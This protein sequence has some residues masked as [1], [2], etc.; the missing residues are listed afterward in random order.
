MWGTEGDGDKRGTDWGQRKVG[1]NEHKPSTVDASSNL[2]DA[3]CASMLMCLCIG[4]PS[5][6]TSTC[7]FTERLFSV[8]LFA[9][10]Y[11]TAVRHLLEASFMLAILTIDRKRFL[12]YFFDLPRRA[13]VMFPPFLVLILLSELFAWLASEHHMFYK[14]LGFARKMI[15]NC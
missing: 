3:T 9:I 10:Q 12:L 13:K 7:I 1:Q 4:S 2:A 6:F 14:F 8:L 5:K 15:S 11:S